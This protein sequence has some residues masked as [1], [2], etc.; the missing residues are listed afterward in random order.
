MTIATAPTTSIN[1]QPLLL[2]V[3]DLTLIVTPE[4][5]DVLCAKNPDLRLELTPHRELIV[6]APAG[7]ES[8]EK[9]ADLVTDVNI[10]NRQALLDRGMIEIDR[11]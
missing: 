7:G 2:D 10:W 9:N 6:M 3:S 8:S 4:Q 5:F 1:T 11:K